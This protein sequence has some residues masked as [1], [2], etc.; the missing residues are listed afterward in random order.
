MF[1][2]GRKRKYLNLTFL[3]IF[4]SVT[5][6]INFFH[7]EETLTE[8]RDCPACQFMH[9][10]LTIS[11]INFFILPQLSVIGFL[12]TIQSS[13]Y[14]NILAVHPFSRSPPQS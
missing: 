11:Q 8:E 4:F 6:F 5:L 14:V 12:Q 10:S 13:H 7:T 9:S 2:K 3:F 1:I